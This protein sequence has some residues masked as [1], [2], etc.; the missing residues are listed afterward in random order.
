MTTKTVAVATVGALGAYGL[1]SYRSSPSPQPGGIAANVPAAQPAYG[2]FGIKSLRLASTELLNHDTK[3]L[4]FA[5][6]D[7]NSSSGLKLTSSMLTIAFPGGRWLPVL[8]PY[9]PVN[10]LGEPLSRTDIVSL[11]C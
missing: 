9:T 3:R 11:T 10:K 6:P 4:R 8:R 2:G 7:E 1:Y 5:L